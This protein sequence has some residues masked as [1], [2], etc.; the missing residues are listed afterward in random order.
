MLHNKLLNNNLLK[1][2]KTYDESLLWTIV[3]ITAFSLIMVFSASIAIAQADDGNKWFF[4]ERQMMFVAMG[5]I[6]GAIAFQFPMKWWKVVTPYVLGISLLL[7][8]LVLFP[9]VGREVNGAKRW[10]PL[11]PVNIQPSEIFKL[12]TV[13]YIASFVTR[14]EEVL[15]N[16][17]KGLLPVAGIMAVGLALIMFEPDFGSF[18][19]VAATAV[20]MLFL[21]GMPIKWFLSTLVLGAALTT[22]LI[23]AAPYRLKRVSGFLDPW[24]DPYGKGYQLTHSL[25][26][27]GRGEWFG[28]GLGGSIEKQFYLP[29]AHTDFIMAVVAEEFGFVGMLALIMVYVWIVWRAFSIG[30]RAKSLE[31]YFSA[32]VAKGIGVWIGIQSFFNIG[33]NLGLLPTKGLTLPLMSYGGSAV[34]V[35]LVGVALLLRIDWENRRLMRGYKL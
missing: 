31:Q 22:T 14:R 25:L 2:G 4:L 12:A 8:L 34:I 11:G 23:L 7:L 5:T 26:A 16:L 35:T 17:R 30:M 33:V 15:G 21:G 27:F 24:A 20:L 6:F 29:E 3:F 32:A 9:G 28:V 18:M 13:L 10:I 1:D 19:M